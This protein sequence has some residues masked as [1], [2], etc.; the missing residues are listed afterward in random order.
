MQAKAPDDDREDLVA[1][2]L[3]AS[4][5]LVGVSARS[6]AD[7][8]ESVSL[9]QFRTLVVLRSQGAST[10]RELATR[11]GV[12]SS[13]A[14]RSVDRLATAGLVERRASDEDRRQVAITLSGS[15]AELVD[16]VTRR[17]RTAIATIVEQMP[18]TQRRH[19][20]RALLAFAEAAGE[21]LA[22]EDAGR[23]GW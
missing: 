1:L 14:M 3:T 12:N 22:A 20:V 13:T 8:E 23:L 16:E 15:G 21:P 4:R 18:T 19:L 6:L 9:A 7:V 5:A 11:L 10:L 17:R 2:L